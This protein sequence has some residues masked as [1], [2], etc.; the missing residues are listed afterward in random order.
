MSFKSIPNVLSDFK[1]IILLSKKGQRYVDMD[2]QQMGDP[3]I[4]VADV[5][6]FRRELIALSGVPAPYL[7]Y[8]EVIELRDHLVHINVTFAA[9]IVS[10]QQV[11]NSGIQE[12]NRKVAKI[13]TLNDNPND[14]VK[15]TLRPPV[16]L[17]L[18][19][20]ET[21]M[22][23]ISNIQQNLQVANISFNPY[24][25]LKRFL[26]TIDWEEF[27]KEADMFELFM[28]GKGKNPDDDT[29]PTQQSNI[30]GKYQ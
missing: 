23:S 3:N 20:I 14:F 15:T 21:I 6:D 25:L 27:S 30:G 8:N 24:Y 29:G 2:L 1:D 22:A 28:K 10:I 13:L 19:M 17:L 16:I 9:E 12:I 5:E 4:R 11:I 18:Q 26:P 7:G